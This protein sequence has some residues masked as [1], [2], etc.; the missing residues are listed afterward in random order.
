MQVM[1][2]SKYNAVSLTNDRILYYEKENSLKFKEHDL[3]VLSNSNEIFE[4][5]ILYKLDQ[6]K[7]ES[8]IERKEFL[9]KNMFVEVKPQ[10]TTEKFAPSTG[11]YQ[12]TIDKTDQML[13]KVTEVEINAPLKSSEDPNDNVSLMA[14]IMNLPSHEFIDKLEDDDDEYTEKY[15]YVEEAVN[16]S[17]D[18]NEEEK[19]L[20]Y[21]EQKMLK[22]QELILKKVRKFFILNCC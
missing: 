15:D 14:K 12:T 11:E 5:V 9:L 8:S 19:N 18:F 17:F 21:Y 16:K 4:Q 13:V 10:S 7:I 20:S 2:S 22:I 3:N 6:S 1:A